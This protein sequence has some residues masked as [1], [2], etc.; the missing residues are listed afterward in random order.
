VLAVVGLGWAAVALTIGAFAWWWWQ[1]ASVTGLNDSARLL[2]W[3]QPDPVSVSAVVL[4]MV[5]GLIALLMVAAA[6]VVAYNTWSGQSWIR[7]GALVCL[8]VGGLSGL[9]NWWF[10]AALVPLALA[11]GLLWLPAVGRF[12]RA[13]DQSRA[14]ELVRVPTSDILYGPQPLIGRRG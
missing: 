4:V 3:V 5:I 2:G 7:V 10:M 11:A 14:I 6:G 12:L 13:M 8:A 9:L 1:A